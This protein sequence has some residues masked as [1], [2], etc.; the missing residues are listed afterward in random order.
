M[1]G[2]SVSLNYEA[3]DKSY[4]LIDQFLVCFDE[5]VSF[6]D[7]FQEILAEEERAMEEKKEALF[8][9]KESLVSLQTSLEA[10]Q[11][12]IE[13]QMVTLRNEIR[14]IISSNQG[15]PPEE[16]EDYSG[17]QASLDQLSRKSQENAEQLRIIQNELQLIDSYMS[18]IDLYLSNISSCMA[19]NERYL[20]SYQDGIPNVTLLKERLMESFQLI[21]QMSKQDADVFHSSSLSMTSENHV[22]DGV[23]WLSGSNQAT[24]ATL[25]ANQGK[26]YD[27]GVAYITDEKG[28]KRYLISASQA[29]GKVGDAIDIALKDGTVLPCL[30]SDAVYSDSLLQYQVESGSTT[31]PWDIE[32]GVIIKNQSETI[33]INTSSNET[34]GNIFQSSAVS[35]SVSSPRTVPLWNYSN[36]E[37]NGNDN[38]VYTVVSGCD[39][40]FPFEKNVDYRI[41]SHVGNRNAPAANA[42]TNHKG[43]DIGVPVGTKVHSLYSGTVLNTGSAS[44]YGKWVQIMQDDGVLVTYGHVSKWD[45]FNV[46]DRVNRGDVIANSGN[47][48]ISTGPHLHLQLEKDGQILNSE[49]YLQNPSYL[50]Y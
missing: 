20:D 34:G 6:L 12:D 23:R 41:T 7:T 36:V 50:G 14:L 2:E 16:Q 33:F 27:H 22:Y 18:D 26:N 32:S 10:E 15:K 45:Y 11:K 47:E 24:I 28:V 37:N 43:T 44:G 39:Y 38:L 5:S 29:Y 4:N 30:I 49:Y 3:L 40:V 21:E 8:Q 1:N 48:G 31:V 42:S 35:S 17:L 25:W 19:D 46:G 9:E 13:S